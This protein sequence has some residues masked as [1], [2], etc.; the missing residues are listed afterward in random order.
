MTI[1]SLMLLKTCAVS[2]T[3]APS[4]FFLPPPWLHAIAPVYQVSLG[5]EC[6]ELEEVSEAQ[7]H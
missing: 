2:F 1:P 5:E 7:D 4:V 6:W 3:P